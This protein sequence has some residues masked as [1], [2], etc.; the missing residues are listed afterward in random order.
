M[1]DPYPRQRRVRSQAFT[2]IEV[3]IVI[4]IISLLA[5]LTLVAVQKVKKDGYIAAARMT[6][7]CLDLALS[8]YRDDEGDLPAGGPGLGQ[9]ENRFPALYRALCGARQ[10]VG[11]GGRSAPYLRP[12]EAD[13]VVLSDESGDLRKAKRGELLDDGV[14]KYLLDP[15][16]EPYVYRVRDVGPGRPRSADIY[17]LGPDRADDHAYG[18]DGDDIGNW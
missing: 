2:L 6:V 7:A 11:P 10:P 8:N 12:K 1:D 9:D 13:L 17:S 18:Q 5:S 4:S 14:D 3:L 16:G 15:F